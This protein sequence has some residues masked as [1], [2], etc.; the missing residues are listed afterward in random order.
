MSDSTST[1]NK[2]NKENNNKI[3]V[4]GSATV[5]NK[6]DE[7]EN[8]LQEIYDL[9]DGK[10]S[11]IITNSNFT[12][13]HLTPLILNLIEVVQNYTSG[14]YEN[15]NGAKKKEIALNVLRHV[16]TDFYIDGKIS[17]NDYDT[18]MIGLEFFGDALIDLGKA[19]WKGLFKVVEDVSE[20]GC[21]G[22]WG[23]NF[24]KKRN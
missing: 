22:C 4:S 11:Q 18:I 19:A 20:N 21:R 5:T 9:L 6:S 7:L 23:R 14:K 16:I 8:D 17:K 13:D 1:E 15:I 12:P 3:E 2:Y 24:F 10:V